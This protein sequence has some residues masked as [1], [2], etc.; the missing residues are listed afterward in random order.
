[1][2]GHYRDGMDAEERLEPRTAPGP[3]NALSATALAVGLAG[4]SFR[5][6]A[7]YIKT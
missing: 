6:P 7:F 4:W 5:F 2:D 3:V 1:M